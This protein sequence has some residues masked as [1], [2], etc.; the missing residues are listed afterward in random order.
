LE[1]EGWVGEFEGR[2]GD[3]NGKERA[4][5]SHGRTM[6]ADVKIPICRLH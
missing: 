6:E 3:W 1:K 5:R 2:G 4:G